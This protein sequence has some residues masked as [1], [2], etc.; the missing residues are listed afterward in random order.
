MR[1]DLKAIAHDLSSD[2]TNNREWLERE[3][4]FVIDG[5]YDSERLNKT[6]L[7]YYNKERDRRGKRGLNLVAQIGIF[8]ISKYGDCNSNQAISV[9]K[10][11][12]KE[13]GII[14]DNLVKDLLDSYM[15]DY[16]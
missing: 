14:L 9:F 2:I 8:F 6:I 16:N 13:N 11:L 3:I 4:S 15:E 7:E 12:S 5:S 10:H 1:K